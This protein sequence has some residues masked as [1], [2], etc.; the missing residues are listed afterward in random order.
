MESIDS[1]RVKY[2]K[3][4]NCNLTIITDTILVMLLES[5]VLIRKDIENCAGMY[6]L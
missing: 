6:L 3:L 2:F 4:W 5:M 1:N